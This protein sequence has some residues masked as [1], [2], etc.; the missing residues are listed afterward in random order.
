[1]QTLTDML[2]SAEGIGFLESNGVFVDRAAFAEQLQLPAKPALATELNQ[3]HKKLI[4]SGQQLY[5]DYRRSV[6]AKIELLR[7][8][9]QDDDCHGF[10][11]WVDT[12][13]SG[14]DN[15]ITKFAWP[16]FSKK[17][18]IS[19]MPARSREVEVRFVELD[20]TRLMSA[21]DKLETYLRQYAKSRKGAKERFLRLRSVFVDGDYDLL[22][23]FNL[24]LTDFLLRD[25]YDYA[26]PAL[27]LSDMLSRQSV[28]DEVELFVNNLKD[29]VAAFN[30]A[31]EAIT[32]QGIDPQVTPLDEDYLPLFFSCRVD[33]QRLRLYLQAEGRDQ[34]AVGRCRCGET[35]KFYLGQQEL[36]LEEIVETGRW[37]P[38]VSFPIFFNDQVSGF[39]AGKSSGIYLMVLNAVMRRAL[40][41]TPVP[42]LI[43]AGLQAGANGSEE[44]DSLIYRYLAQ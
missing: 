11:L 26:P 31:V 39:V 13:R 1:M 19:I 29:V 10:F 36:S 28:I 42:V 24:S 23:G 34:F 2:N 27:L 5:V 22:G 9:A 8:M 38:D 16:N 14:S 44:P 30:E 37:S 43:P 32:R 35:V 6:L 25:V 21:I 15:L 17:G 18:P 4:C 12:D 33:D 40:A 3:P 41:K 7:E 20:Q